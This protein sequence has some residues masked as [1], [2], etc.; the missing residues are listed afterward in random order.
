MQAASRVAWGV[1][2]EGSDTRRWG[3]EIA[4]GGVEG[5]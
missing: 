5:R 3:A 4:G 1:S 2:P